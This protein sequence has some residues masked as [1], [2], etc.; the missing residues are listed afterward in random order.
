MGLKKVEVYRG[1]S[2]YTEELQAG[3]WGISAV[4]VP[5]GGPETTRSPSQGRVPGTHQSKDAAR[6]AARAHIDRI[7]KN[8]KNRVVQ[9]AG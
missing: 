6:E 9:D 3:V 2:I 4:E 7:L 1:F 8:R 5:S